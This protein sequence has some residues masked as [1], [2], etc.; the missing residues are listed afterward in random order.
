MSDQFAHIGRCLDLQER[1]LT[2]ALRA[3]ATTKALLA[4]LAAISAPNS[5]AAKV[6]IVFSRMATTACNWIDGDLRIDVVGDAEET[7]IEAAT[8]LG[9]G[10]RERLF[11]PMSFRA[12]IAEFARA[13]DRVPHMIVPLVV[14]A[15]S[16]HRVSLSANEVL[17]R[18][19][20]PP[21]PI[22][23]SANSLFVRESPSAVSAESNEVALPSISPDDVD[24]GWED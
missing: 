1:D 7:V 10:L 4:H 23:I 5:G 17:R 13:I 15:K 2:E 18:T 8:E 16:A 20:A 19:T 14:R 24:A 12:P 9:G 21:P 3:R 6:L 11:A 22:E